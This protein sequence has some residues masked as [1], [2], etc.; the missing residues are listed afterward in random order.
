[1][2]QMRQLRPY[3]FPPGS[4]PARPGR[5]QVVNAWERALLFRN[6][7]LVRTL[8]PGAY[9]QWAPGYRLQR[10]DV[11][12]WIL[13]VPMQEVPTSDSVTVKVSAA[14]R[15]R[16]TDPVAFVLAS[17]DPV[18][19]LYLAVQ[20]ALREL[21]AQSSVDDLVTGR[22][23]I[24]TRLSEAV[25]EVAE[26]GVTV[27]QLEVKDIVLPADLK[28]AQ[29]QVLIARADGLAAL[30]RARGET[31][32]LRNLANAARLLSDNPVLLQLRLFQQLSSTTGHTVVI[33]G[34]PLGPPLTPPPPGGTGGAG[35]AGPTQEEGDQPSG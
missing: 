9:R 10:V 27:E 19:A 34:P 23:G 28:R 12:P 24:G 33:G 2:R 32:A 18:A 17:Q 29:A 11:R 16:V 1:M 31:A 8:D 26:L 30:E 25:R 5:R 14:G 22:G 13:Q 3:R 6:G 7:V 20:V 4:V 15:V 21:V 35:P